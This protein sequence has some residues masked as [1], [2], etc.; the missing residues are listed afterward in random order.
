MTEGV[1]RVKLHKMIRVKLTAVLIK[2]PVLNV[3]TDKEE[4][5]QVMT[6]S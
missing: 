2:G 5:V 4:A 1:L 3:V 6:I